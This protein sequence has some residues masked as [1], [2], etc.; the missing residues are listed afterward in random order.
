M[1]LLKPHTADRVEQKQMAQ[2][3]CH[4]R[5]RNL[6]EDDFVLVHNN[7]STDQ[8][9]PGVVTKKAVTHSDTGQ[10]INGQERGCHLDQHIEPEETPDLVIP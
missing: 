7:H 10:L 6:N 1:D 8:R 3:S 5:D 4:A 2:K 9:L